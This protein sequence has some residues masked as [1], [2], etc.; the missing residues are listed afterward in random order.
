MRKGRSRRK[1]SISNNNNNGNGNGN[2]SLGVSVST[3]GGSMS[4][5]SSNDGSLP[6]RKPISPE[7]AALTAKNY[8]LAREL[9]S[10]RIFIFDSNKIS[11][12][13]RIYGPINPTV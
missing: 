1:N 6:E 13:C 4:A 12:M 8:R 7:E 5:E 11:L 2:G 10:L 3:P 9:V